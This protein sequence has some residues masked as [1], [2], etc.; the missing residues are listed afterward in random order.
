LRESKVRGGG[1]Q[2]GDAGWSS[3]LKSPEICS[4]MDST[5][6]AR[7]QERT[8][9]SVIRAVQRNLPVELEYVTRFII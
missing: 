9:L 4:G 3:L 5:A 7:G 2:E 8:S 1:S 6:G